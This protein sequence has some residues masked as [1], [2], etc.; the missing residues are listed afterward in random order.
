MSP[1]EEQFAYFKARIAP[2]WTRNVWHHYRQRA[3][4]LEEEYPDMEGLGAL[5][6]AELARIKE[7]M[8]TVS[9]QPGLERPCID[10]EK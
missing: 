9:K 5:M 3:T 8:Q 1:L 2:P 10:K 6:D 4:D 7:A